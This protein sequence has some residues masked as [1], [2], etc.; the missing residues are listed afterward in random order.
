MLFADASFVREYGP[1]VAGFALAALAGIWIGQ[2]IRSRK[3]SQKGVHPADMK[4]HGVL[5]IEQSQLIDEACYIVHEVLLPI[6]QDD[7]GTL[8]IFILESFV[9]LGDPMPRLMV[10]M[11]LRPDTLTLLRDKRL[12]QQPIAMQ[13]KNRRPTFE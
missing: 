3:T 9:H 13:W 2:S 7:T 5:R 4:K 6:E 12:A 8:V 10:H 1:M 11:M